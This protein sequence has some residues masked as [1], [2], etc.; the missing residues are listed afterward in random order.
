MSLFQQAALALGTGGIIAIAGQGIVQVYRGSGVLNFAHGAFALASAET[1]VWLWDGHHVPVAIAAAL[2]V[3]L[4]SLLGVVTHLVVM[5]PLQRASVLVRIIATIGVLQVVQQAT[6]LV[7]GSDERQVG[8]F[9]PRGAVH[10]GDVSLTK[11]ALVVVAVAVLLT[12]LLRATMTTTPF[13]RATQAVA[14]SH[15]VARSLGHSPGRVALANWAIGGALAGLAGVL[16]VPIGGLAVNSILLIAVPA[17]AAAI[18]GGFRSYL[19]TTVG[20][21]AIAIGQS[22]CTFQSVAHNWPP[23]VPPSL[24]FLVV[25]VALALRRTALPTRDDVAA[26]LPR[27]ARSVPS[28]LV[29]AAALAGCVALSLAASVSLANAL[30]TTFTAAIVGLSLVVVTGLSGQISLAQYSLAGIAALAAARA[31]HSL[32]WPFV[33][34]LAVGVVASAASGVVFALPSLRT[35]GP[36]LAVVT[37]GLGL[38]VQQGVLSDRRLTAGFS[39]ATPVHRPTFFG[40][41]LSAVDHPGRYAAVCAVVFVLLAAGIATLRASGVGRRLLAVRNNERA[42]LALGV[43]VAGM[44]LYAFVVG[45]AVAGVGGVLLAFRFDTAQYGQFGFFD[46]LTIVT[47]VLIGGIGYVL[48]PLVGALGVPGAVVSY[49]ASN[50]GDLTRWLV[51]GSGAIL[52]LTLVGMPDGV[53]ADIGDRLVRRRRATPVPV[54]AGPT[55]EAAPLAKVLEIRDLVVAFGV[56]RALDGAAVRVE[57]GRVTGLIGANGAGKSTLID[58]VSGFNGVAGGTILLDGTDVAALSPR[59][60]ARAGIGRCFQSIELFEDLTVAENLLVGIDVVRPLDWLSAFVRRRPLAL[61]ADALAVVDELELRDDLHRLPAELSHG[62]RRLVGVARAL[63]ARPSVLLLDEP[64]AGL[65]AAERLHLGT[66][67]R[68]V[69]NRGVG[70][71]L[72]DHDV[73]LVLDA[74]DH[75]VAIDFGRVIYDGPPEGVP[76]SEEVRLAY[77][78]ESHTVE[79]VA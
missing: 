5:H 59:G 30:I 55:R 19:L 20:A 3:G 9:L 58:T 36:A 18:L 64:A 7:F 68:A 67:V 1:F 70:V 61:P 24:P 47:V 46:S 22:V 35:R 11:A 72:V 76:S 62:K 16:I 21:I 14:E 28:P 34:C 57:P 12:A 74:S 6:L 13:G 65:D 43:P 77:L 54:A 27:V 8:S 71:L 23:G 44:K 10:V 53:L 41:D 56:V 75:V 45:A 66:V 51:L 17:F 33:A 73:D 29:I 78:G 4:G 48:G 49:F 50:V 31:S 25:V 79:A 60:R 69:A 40:L 42:A 26:R 32:G 15:L 39:G 2:A 38:A 52:V 37:I 63:V